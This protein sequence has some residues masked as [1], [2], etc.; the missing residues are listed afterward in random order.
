MLEFDSV[1]QHDPGDVIASNNRALAQVWTGD[2]AAGIAS[3]ETAFAARPDTHMRVSHLAAH[4]C[5]NS[6]RN[7]GKQPSKIRAQSPSASFSL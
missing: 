6:S 2:L 1:C 4:N 3:L 7:I 5:S